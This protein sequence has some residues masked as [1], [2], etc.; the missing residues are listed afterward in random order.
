MSEVYCFLR[1]HLRV[2]SKIPVSSS[3]P[4]VFLFASSHAYSIAYVTFRA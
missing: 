3:V 2:F 4:A 1:I